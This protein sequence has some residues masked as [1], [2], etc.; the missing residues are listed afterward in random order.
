MAA[1]IFLHKTGTTAGQRV[2]KEKCANCGHT[3]NEHRYGYG[4]CLNVTPGEHALFDAA[5]PAHRRV[6]RTDLTFC[7]CK[8]LVAAP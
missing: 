5:N 6:V 2:K 7:A 1:L 3:A 8:R 4:P